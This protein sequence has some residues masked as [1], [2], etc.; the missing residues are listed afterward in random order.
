MREDASK[1]VQISRAREAGAGNTDSNREWADHHVLAQERD[2][3]SYDWQAP[4]L[5]KQQQET[6][7]LTTGCHD[8][9]HYTKQH[10]SFKK[11]YVLEDFEK[12]RT[13][14]QL[15]WFQKR[16]SELAKKDIEVDETEFA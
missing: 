10:Q 16:T 1:E 14:I 13:P 6:N 3:R 9:D 2:L 7:L 5:L 11:E 8:V 12:E 15:R 4:D